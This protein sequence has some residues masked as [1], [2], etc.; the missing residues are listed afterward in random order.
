MTGKRWKNPDKRMA[1][2]VDLR[3]RGWSLRK[4]GTELAVS[5]ITIRRDLA[6]WDREQFDALAELDDLRH[7]AAT[8]RSDVASECRSDVAAK[9]DDA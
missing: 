5:E 3:R 6:R 7:V 9:E 2:A 4:I 1:E 8:F